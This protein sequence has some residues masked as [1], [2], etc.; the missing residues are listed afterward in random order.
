MGLIYGSPDV[1]RTRRAGDQMQGRQWATT[2]RPSVPVSVPTAASW[3]CRACE[4]ARRRQQRP[5]A[6]VRSCFLKQH[7]EAAGRLRLFQGRKPEPAE[8]ER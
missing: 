6:R 3:L 2:G 1:L 4:G 5:D 8:G 7:H